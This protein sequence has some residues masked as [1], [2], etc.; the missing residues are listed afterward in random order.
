MLVKRSL[1]WL[2]AVLLWGG[3]VQGQMDPQGLII[4]TEQGGLVYID[5]GQR[6]GVMSGDMYDIVAPDSLLYPGKP[7]SVIAITQKTVGALRVRQVWEKTSLA[8]LLHIQAG[9][10]PMLKQIVLI[11]D[12]DR[13]MEIDK[14]TD[15][16][17]YGAAG[18]ISKNAALVPGLYQ[19]KMG[20]KSKG[21]SLIGLE[22][23]ALIGAIAYRTDSNDWYDTYNNLPAGLPEER[24]AFYFDGAQDRRNWSNR[25]FWLAGALYAYNLIDAIWL[26]GT[27]DMHLRRTALPLGLGADRRGRPTLQWVHRF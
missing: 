24:Y 14:F 10:N 11:K 16:W 23:V 27:Q 19:L 7:D 25:L 26:S 1:L 22:A 18:G 20:E 4:K 8:Q 15:R 5:L 21:W 2:T 13:I 17:M 9:E 3:A 6:D 12:A